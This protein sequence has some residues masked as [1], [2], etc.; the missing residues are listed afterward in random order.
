MLTSELDYNLPP[1]LIAQHP[2]V[3]R[4]LSRLLVHDR[5]TDS[6]EHRRLPGLLAHLNPGDALVYN[7]SRV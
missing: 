1:E 7:D 5:L 6:M 2:V 4:D 3:P